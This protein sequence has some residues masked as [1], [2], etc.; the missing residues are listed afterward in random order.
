VNAGKVFCW[1]TNGAGQVG[2]GAEQLSGYTWYDPKEVTVL[3]TSAKKVRAG[4]EGSCALLDDASLWCWGASGARQ[5]GGMTESPARPIQV[6]G[7]PRKVVDFAMGSGWDCA[8][9]E[10]ESLWCWGNSDAANVRSA[11]PVLVGTI[12]ALS[13]LSLQDPPYFVTRAGAVSTLA[14]GALVPVTE[15]G[16]DIVQMVRGQ[17]HQCGLRRD[18]SVG[19]RGNDAEGQLGD[20]SRSN[21]TTVV[22]ATS[23]GRNNVELLAVRYSTCARDPGG[24]VRCVG[25][26]DTPL[27]RLAI[28]CE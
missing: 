14:K 3:P 7:L 10:D 5:A 8:Y 18:G 27:G 6:Q 28:P 23:L 22:E 12:P 16:P 26:F 9:L 2:P 15:F 25:R 24:T 4:Y 21:T 19:C 11:S 13:S 17:Y 1:G 20:G